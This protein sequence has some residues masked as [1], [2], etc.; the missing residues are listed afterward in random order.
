MRTEPITPA[1]LQRSVI[2]VPPLARH[3]DFSLNREA[4]RALLRHLEGAGVRSVMYG[5]NANFYHLG[6]A[7]Y[8]EVID[9]LAEAA[10]ADTW[11]LPAAG[12]DFGKLLDQAAVLRTRAFP[13]AMLLP[14]SFPFTHDG[15]AAGVRR[16]TDALGK[17]AVLYLKSEPYLRPETLAQLYEEKRI[18]AVKYAV[19]RANPAVDS[20]LGEIARVMDRARVV[21]G[22]GERPVL[23]HARE[24]GLSSFTS[25]SICVAPHGSMAILEALHHGRYVEAER[26]R[27][28]YLPLEDLRDELSPIR[29]LHEAVTLAGIADMGPLLPLLTGLD[30][31]E[32]A[33]VA[34]V[35]QRLA[36]LDRTRHAAVHAQAAA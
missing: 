27:G 36:E 8:A 21:S 16:F 28:D 2:A 23:T 9:F 14:M 30:A 20:Y 1:H 11:V 35:A 19:V 13:T 6:L 29:V 32:R 22:S 25:G 15:L 17:P 24:F 33:R 12:P 18:A 10:G 4:N 31:A 3:A 5:G 34:P 26:L 7:E